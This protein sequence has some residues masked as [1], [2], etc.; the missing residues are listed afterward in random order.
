M[1]MPSIFENNFV[2]NFFDDMFSMPTTYRRREN[3]MMKTDVRDCG[4]CYELDM[5]LPGYKKEDIQAEL[6]DGNLT[7]SA[8]CKQEKEEKDKNG[9]FVRRERYTG[10]CQRSFYVGEQVKQEDIQAAFQDG[11][12]KLRVPKV[13]ERPAVEE[14]KYIAIQ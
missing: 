7:I 3:A 5:E 8:Q 12:L 4:D 10:R 1:F 2:D 14:R 9:N 11:I 13:E 6:K